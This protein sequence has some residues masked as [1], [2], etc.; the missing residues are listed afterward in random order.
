MHGHEP[1]VTEVLVLPYASLSTPILSVCVCGGGGGGGSGK[2]ACM[3][4][5]I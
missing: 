1:S 2:I 5:C 4:S 3:R